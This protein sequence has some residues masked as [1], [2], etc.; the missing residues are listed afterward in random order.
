MANETILKRHLSPIILST[1]TYQRNSEWDSASEKYLIFTSTQLLRMGAIIQ[2]WM[3]LLILLFLILLAF[4]FPLLI[5]CFGW[6]PDRG[7]RRDLQHNAFWTFL[8][9]FPGVIHAM[10]YATDWWNHVNGREILC[11]VPRKQ[12][13]LPTE[14]VR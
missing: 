5:I 4:I 11:F 2:T 12:W 6:I 3:K 1:S 7:R 13:R 9:W 8:L 14:R 10:L